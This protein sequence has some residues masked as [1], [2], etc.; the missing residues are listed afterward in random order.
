MCEFLNDLRNLYFNL[1]NLQY[2]FA[3]YEFKAVISTTR[4]ADFNGSNGPGN[5]KSGR[6]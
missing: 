2:S 5:S 1:R 3:F 6:N 4:R